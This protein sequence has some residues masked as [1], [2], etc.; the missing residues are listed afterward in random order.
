MKATGIIRKIDELGRV[1]IPKEIRTKMLVSPGDPIEI[2][3]Q[4][5]MICFKKVNT[6]G[7]Y[8]DLFELMIN[9]L[10]SENNSIHNTREVKQKLNELIVELK[11]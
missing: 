7:Y 6:A 10:D 5:N 11:K 9:D 3:T 1:V 8:I 2:F 4:D